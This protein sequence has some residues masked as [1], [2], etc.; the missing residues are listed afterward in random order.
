MLDALACSVIMPGIESEDAIFRHYSQT[1]MDVYKFKNLLVNHRS[2]VWR[3]H[4]CISSS[5]MTK[6]LM[7]EAEKL[8]T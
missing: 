4:R 6:N 8:K 3:W 7:M 5:G 2:S 1:T